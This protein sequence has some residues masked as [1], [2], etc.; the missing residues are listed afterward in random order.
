MASRESRSD[1]CSGRKLGVIFPFA[2]V[3]ESGEGGPASALTPRAA[4]AIVEPINAW[5]SAPMNER[6]AA[7][8]QVHL[9]AEFL[10]HRCRPCRSRRCRSQAL[11][12][13]FNLNVHNKNDAI[14][15]SAENFAVTRFG[16]YRWRLQTAYL[17]SSVFDNPQ[18]RVNRGACENCTWSAR[19]GSPIVRLGSR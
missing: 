13:P 7:A 6:E 14:R 12:F 5:A 9:L 1:V 15:W 11:A 3:Y 8:R 4:V 16:A 10:R 18:P 17:R 2:S 19:R